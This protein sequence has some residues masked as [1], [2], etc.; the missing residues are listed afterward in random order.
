MDI[1]T[2]VTEFLY[3]GAFRYQ[4]DN[5][6][7][8]IKESICLACLA[9]FTSASWFD[10][11]SGYPARMPRRLEVRLISCVLYGVALFLIFHMIF[12]TSILAVAASRWLSLPFASVIYRFP[13][14]LENWLSVFLFYSLAAFAIIHWFGVDFGLAILTGFGVF[15]YLRAPRSALRAVP[16]LI[17]AV[18]LL[19]GSALLWCDIRYI[20]RACP[21][22]NK[23]SP[24]E[25]AAERAMPPPIW[26]PPPPLL[27]LPY[28]RD[29]PTTGQIYVPNKSWWRK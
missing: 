23:E 9:G 21:T 17:P 25:Q 28:L 8:G 2:N 27:T 20:D 10:P 24:A 18:W 14:L 26:N 5:V 4:T 16:N 22:S 7:L 12:L 11:L 19:L 15:G 1:F 3:G 13:C 6:V 29:C